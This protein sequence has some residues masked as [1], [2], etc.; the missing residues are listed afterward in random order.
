MYR[1]TSGRSRITAPVGPGSQVRGGTVLQSYAPRRRL[2]RHLPGYV[3]KVR[4]L[5]FINYS[6]KAIPMMRA[7]APQFSPIATRALPRQTNWIQWFV[8]SQIVC[9]LF[10]LTDIT[11]GP[12]RAV[13][14]IVAFSISLF[15]LIFLRGASRS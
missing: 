1:P 7:T 13:V 3:G 10:L 12:F 5:F 8:I 2:T 9:Q 6:P 15:F 14:R 4:R 11:T